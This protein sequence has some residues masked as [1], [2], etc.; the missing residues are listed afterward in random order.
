ML[1]STCKYKLNSVRDSERI[2]NKLFLE[3]YIEEKTGFDIV[4]IID[5][6]FRTNL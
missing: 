2:I 3:G 5:H 4:H 6:I 1:L